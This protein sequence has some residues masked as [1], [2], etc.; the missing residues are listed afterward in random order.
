MPVGKV[1][2]QTHHYERAAGDNVPAAP[3]VIPDRIPASNESSH[4]QPA[5]C[6][7]LHGQLTSAARVN[8]PACGG[9]ID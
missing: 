2:R 3:D 4:A 9:V 7:C 1:R 6:R 8:P 5:L